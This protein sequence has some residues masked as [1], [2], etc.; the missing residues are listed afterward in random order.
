MKNYKPKWLWYW[1]HTYDIEDHYYTYQGSVSNIDIAKFLNLPLT[2]DVLA[3]IGKYWAT[4]EN[5]LKDDKDFDDF[6]TEIYESD[7]ID[8]FFNSDK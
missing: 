8:E 5:M 1:E 6:L 7:A 4:Y 2:E 3:S